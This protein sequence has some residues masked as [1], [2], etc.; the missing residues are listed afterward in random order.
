MT[1][2]LLYLFVM[3]LLLGA[4]ACA[5]NIGVTTMSAKKG[6]II[7]Y[8][9]PNAKDQCKTWTTPHFVA[10]RNGK[11]TWNIINEGTTCLDGAAE[12]EIKFDKKDADPFPSCNKKNKN[13]IE[14][15]VP[16]NAEPKGYKYSVWLSGAQEDPEIQIEM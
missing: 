10:K 3:S 8:R 14:C 9:D 5:K 13:K 4:S 12:I 1:K 7:V 15:D 2:V 6:S 11:A 16:E